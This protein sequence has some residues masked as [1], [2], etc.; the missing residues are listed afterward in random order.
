[1]PLF[2]Y[3]LFGMRGHASK[4]GLKETCNKKKGWGDARLIITLPFLHICYTKYDI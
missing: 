3:A 1:M 4:I 2:G